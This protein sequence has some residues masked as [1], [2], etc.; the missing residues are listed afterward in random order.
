M[1]LGITANIEKKEVESTIP[2]VL[3]WLTKK[4]IKHV[5]DS[6]LANHLNLPEKVSRIRANRFYESCDMVVS[7]G[8]DGTILS[9]A[10]KIGKS[11]VP[12]LGVKIGGLGFL[13]DLTPEE[14]YSSLDDILSGKSQIVDRM[15]LQ[16]E[17]RQNNKTTQ[18]FALNDFVFNKGAVSRLIRIKTFI[19]DHYLNTYIAD[20]LIISTPTGSTAYSLSA[21]GPILL[22]S[23]EAIIVNPLN[24]H[25]L[26]A[27]PVVIPG[28]KVVKI[29]LEDVP[30]KV[31][32]SADGQVSIDVGSDQ[33]VTLSKADFRIR[34]VSYQ[35]RDFYKV[36]RSKLNWGGDIRKD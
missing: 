3:D 16:A 25:T 9:T 33:P 8:G 4:G 7:F 28:D 21:G 32:L 23:M 35:S 20:G 34:L 5:V 10:R 19:D 30:Q 24:P 6:E 2:K 31:Q 36:L 29:M 22:P 1:K 12:I 15:V 11:G 26:G 18:L 27:R 14:F 17:I 13:A